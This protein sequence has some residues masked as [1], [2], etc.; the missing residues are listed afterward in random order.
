MQ[1]SFL[2]TRGG[3]G[4]IISRTFAETHNMPDVAKNLLDA[5]CREVRRDREKIEAREKYGRSMN[6]IKV[7]GDGSGSHKGSAGKG[8]N[9]EAMVYPRK[10]GKL[11][12]IP[13]EGV[14]ICYTFAKGQPGACSE[15]CPNQRCPSY[16]FCLGPHPNSQCLKKGGGKGK[17]GN[18]SKRYVELDSCLLDIAILEVE[19]KGG[20]CFSFSQVNDE[21]LSDLPRLFRFAKFFAGWDGY[22][23]KGKELCRDVNH[24][25]F[26]PPCRRFICTKKNDEFGNIKN[27]RADIMP[28]EGQDAQAVEAN[29]IITPMVALCLV[30][31]NSG[32]IFS[33]EK[34]W[35]NFL[36]ML[37]IMLKLMSLKQVELVMVHQCAFA[38][39]SQKAT[40]ILTTSAWMKSVKAL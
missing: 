6:E 30:L 8:Q 1:S 20:S 37:H 28:E 19:D 40:G 33:V 7:A 4:K 21:R 5:K 14:Q 29:L 24:G 38:I 13:R 27:L 35:V 18:V 11:F 9:H 25:H 3:A 32:I 39:Y 12:M 22:F 23:E 31:H 2:V 34:R 15:P 17:A 26:A 16:Q 36:S 10:Y